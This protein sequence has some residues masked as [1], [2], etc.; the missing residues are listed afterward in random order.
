M[1]D[2]VDTTLVESLTAAQESQDWDRVLVF[3]REHWSDLFQHAPDALLDVIEALPPQV[4]AQNS[5]LRLADDY[6]RRTRDRR[7]ETRAYRDIIADDPAAAP[8]DRL[9]ALTGRI[10]VLRQAG[11]HRDAVAATDLAVSALRGMPVEI[12][13]TFTNALPEFHYHWGIAYLLVSRF[14]D[15]LEQFV[16]SHDWAAS[17]GNHIVTARAA[18]G[19]ALIHAVH[20]RGR[21]AEDWLAKLPAVPEDA[22]WAADASTPSRLAEAILH[23]ERLEADAARVV[24]SSIDIRLSLDY[25]GPYFAMR[26][27]LTPDHPADAQA[28]LTEFDAFVSGL[29]PAYANAPLNAEYTALVRYLLLQILHQ[30][31]RAMRALGDAR[32]D[33]DANVTRQT[34]ATLLAIRLVQLDRGAEARKL[35]AP[36]LHVSS[37]RPRV[38]IPAL[39]IAAETDAVD[40]REALLQRATA[41]AVWNHC[42]SALTFGPAGVRQRLAALLR[43]RGEGEVA[44]RLLGVAASTPIAGTDALTKRE[45]AVVRAALAGRSNIEI[46]EEQH[47]SVNTVKTH[48]RTAYRKLQVSNREQLHQLFQLGR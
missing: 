3:M 39:L 36:L 20:G 37:A 15:A 31:D 14:D 18:G 47:V 45:T 4:L 29:A 17:V 9:A 10:A 25:W 32:V 22:W 16:Q 44:D 11:R 13:P 21:D 24:L 46:A 42:H 35:I 5:R 2:P 40:H 27:F 28:L 6:L 12:I 38:L 30:P 1:R 43:E 33:A 41:L 34:S 23:T 7:P 26:A 48:L 19:A 8:L